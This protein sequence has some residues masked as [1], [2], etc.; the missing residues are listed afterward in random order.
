MDKRNRI[1]KDLAKE[2]GVSQQTICDITK[3]RRHK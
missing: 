2:F 1:G 3:G